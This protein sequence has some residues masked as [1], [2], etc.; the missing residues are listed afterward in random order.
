MPPRRFFRYGFSGRSSRPRSSSRKC[1]KIGPRLG[2][3]KPDMSRIL[4]LD[5]GDPRSHQFVRGAAIAIEAELDVLGGDGVAVVEFGPVA[6][7]EF[8]GEPVFADR[9]RFGKARRQVFARHRLHHRVVQRIEDHER[10]DHPGRLGRVEPARR[11]R[12]M[13]PAGQF[14]LRRCRQRWRSGRETECRQQQQLAAVDG[15]VPAVRSGCGPIT[16]RIVMTC[17]LDSPFFAPA[18]SNRCRHPA[19]IV[20]AFRSQRRFGRGRRSC[21]ARIGGAAPAGS[22]AARRI[23]LAAIVAGRS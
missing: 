8:V 20:P 9:P 7:H 12:D 2:Q 21:I 4:D 10:R 14:A 6:Q 22:G 15:S 1:Q 5:R 23:R 13:H 18:R 16:R 17:S 11:Q 3:A 19:P